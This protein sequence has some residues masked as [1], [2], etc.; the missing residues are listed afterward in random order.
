M[1]DE[2]EEVE[3]ELAYESIEELISEETDNL[4]HW[5]YDDPVE[6]DGYTISLEQRFGGS[7]G[8]GEEHWIVLRFEKE[9]EETSFWLIPGWYQSY[10][11]AELEYGDAYRVESYERVVRDWKA[12]GEEAEA[13]D[14]E[15]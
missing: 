7:Q 15:E 13:D 10:N 8:A 14:D 11:G 3:G 5:R 1:S 6:V 4:P 12:Y 2:N 9:G